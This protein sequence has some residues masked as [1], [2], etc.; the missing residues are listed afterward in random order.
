MTRQRLGQHFLTDAAWRARIA[1]AIGVE[2]GH[3]HVPSG[4]QAPWLEIGAG[5]GEMTR[6]LAA[7]SAPVYAVEL[8]PRLH[9][10]LCEVAAEHP[11]IHAIGADI[12]QLD[13]KEIAAG[14]RLRVYGNLPYYIT[15]PILHRLFEIAERIDV[16]H[17]VMQLEV[18][19]R[20]VAR[21][22]TRAYGY[23]SVA[24]QY[25]TRPE[26]TLRIPRGAFRP[27]PKVTS[28]LVALRLPGERSCLDVRDEG[29]F[30]NFVK[31]AFAQKRK[32]LSNNLRSLVRPERTAEALAEMGLQRDARA[33]QLSVAQ[34]AQLF[35]C[36]VGV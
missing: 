18:A 35:R 20:L 23:L 15:S 30:L 3:G 11:S 19:R 32:T 2:P 12:L 1:R 14:S 33:E 17:L 6:L 16:I 21:P 22:G 25:F 28:A 10:R 13:L 8:D 7:T 5:H 29:R 4:A 26:I 27:P 34:L 24:T 31:L 9:K 36:L